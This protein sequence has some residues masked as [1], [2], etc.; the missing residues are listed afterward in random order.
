MD[1]LSQDIQGSVGT[2]RVKAGIEKYPETKI[3]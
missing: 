3:S 2:R 1:W